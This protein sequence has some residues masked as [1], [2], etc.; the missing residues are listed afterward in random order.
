LAFHGEYDSEEV[1]H[2]K[3]QGTDVSVGVATQGEHRS[4]QMNASWTVNAAPTALR[5]MT[6]RGALGNTPSDALYVRS[7]TSVMKSASRKYH[8]KA[9]R[10]SL[11]KVW[12][13]EPQGCL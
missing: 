13:C 4:S 3:E 6:K 11:L 12:A 1:L 9:G 10:N 5:M 7:Y 2:E 8:I